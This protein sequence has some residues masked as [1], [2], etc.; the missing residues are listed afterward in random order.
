MVAGQLGPQAATPEEVVTVPAA[1]IIGGVIGAVK[2]YYTDVVSDIKGQKGRL[3]ETPIRTLSESKSVLSDIINA[4]NANP[5]NARENL[6]AFNQINQLLDDEFDRLKGLTDDDLNKY[7]G[8]DGINQMQEY[9]VYMYSGEK[10]RLIE[11]MQIAQA[12][13]DPA[14]VRPDAIS[15]KQINKKIEDELNKLA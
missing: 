4:Q 2:G 3:I 5:E 7:L 13:P 11:E 1:A 9:E 6:E 15:I 10:Y 14:R 12:N 8:V